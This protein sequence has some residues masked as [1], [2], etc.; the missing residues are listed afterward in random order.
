L[1]EYAKTQKEI[2]AKLPKVDGQTGEIIYGISITQLKNT[3][4]DKPGFPQRT[5]KGWNVQ[6]CIAFVLSHLEQME[7]NTTGSELDDLKKRE[8]IKNIRIQRARAEEGLR[9]D[10]IKTAEAEGAVLSMDEHRQSH[11]IVADAV[12][13]ALGAFVHRVG[14]SLRSPEAVKLSEDARDSALRAI[15]EAIPVE[16]P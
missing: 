7:A 1:I 5:A 9:Q 8:Q 12:K 3:W 14:V 13:A 11:A 10:R 15:Q 4:V 6:E 2:A 16:K